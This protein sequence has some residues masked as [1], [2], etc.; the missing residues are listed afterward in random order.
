MI[1]KTLGAVSLVN[2]R[3]C[4]V[5]G[6][7]MALKSSGSAFDAAL[8]R[9]CGRRPHVR[10]HVCLGTV[11]AACRVSQPTTRTVR[12]AFSTTHVCTA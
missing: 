10:R 2:R 1:E 9:N 8:A 4:C 3:V 7:L 11:R 12:N 6:G 5:S